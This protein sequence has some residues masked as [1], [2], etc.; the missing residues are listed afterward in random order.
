M[1][2]E[3][4]VVVAV[5]RGQFRNPGRGTSA[6]GSWYQGTGEQTDWEDSVHAQ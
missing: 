5:A 2:Y 1:H 4:R 6:S 3:S